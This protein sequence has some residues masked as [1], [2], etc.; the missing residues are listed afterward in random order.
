MSIE[1]ITW[2]GMIDVI[3]SRDLNSLQFE[4]KIFE[5]SN[6]LPIDNTVLS[7]MVSVQAIE[8][9][10]L[11]LLENVYT[12]NVQQEELFVLQ[13]GT[14]QLSVAATTTSD[15]THHWLQQNSTLP[16]SGGAVY[17][18]ELG[19]WVAQTHGRS[20]LIAGNCIGLCKRNQIGSDLDDVLIGDEH[21]NYLKGEKGNDLLV[22]G[23]GNDYYYFSRGDGKDI[24]TEFDSEHGLPQPYPG[25]DNAEGTGIDVLIFGE[26]IRPDQLNFQRIGFE[27]HIYVF[28]TNDEITIKDWFLDYRAKIEILRFP[29]IGEFDI[30]GQGFYE[31]ASNIKDWVTGDSGDNTLQGLAGDDIISGRDGDD[32]LQGDEGND[33]LIGGLGADTL[34]GGEGSD[35]A[36]Y[37]DSKQAININLS[38]ETLATGG[39]AAGD[40][41]QSIENVVGSD[42]NDNINGDLYNNI[43]KGG[44]GNDKLH[45]GDGADTLQGDSGNDEIYGERGSDTING[46]QGND[47]LYGGISNDVISGGEGM[48]HLY[49]GDHDDTLQGDSGDDVLHGGADQDA[50]S[51][52]E[53][54]DHLYGDGGRD[55]LKGGAGNDTLEG[56]SDDDILF[57]DKGADTLQGED[58]DDYLSGGEGDDTLLSGGAGNDVIEGGSGEDRLQG[59]AGEDTLVG[60]N[61]D[62]TIIAGSGIDYLQG[63][64]GNDRLEGGLDTD[65]YIFNGEFGQDVIVEAPARENRDEIVFSGYQLSHLWFQESG[66]NLIITLIGTENQVTLLNYR[67]FAVSSDAAGNAVTEIENALENKTPISVM[68]SSIQRLDSTALK[69]VIDEMANYEVPTSVDDTPVIESL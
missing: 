29:L 19:G 46:N 23:Y 69:N 26:N 37:Y 66:T 52:G 43:I 6:G 10:E 55:D 58:G 41:Y 11:A 1:Q 54:D 20:V 47:K 62:D 2:G 25:T 22:G 34:N 17:S 56:G 13:P 53:G 49:G 27:L 64:A 35:A 24:F 15:F 57:G 67:N 45:G 60:Q 12:F 42:F 61:G 5:T 44:A 4:L 40:T 21:T 32:E 7:K 68:S 18:V 3:D 30:S 33:T 51:G 28:E 8:L 36:I 9:N 65:V 38:N 63:G 31:D 16:A 48:D 59:G 50:L 14:Y 39:T